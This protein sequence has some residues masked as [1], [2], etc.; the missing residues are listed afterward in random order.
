MWIRNTDFI[1]LL[2]L[3]NCDFITG[4][5]QHVLFTV[6]DV[7]KTERGC[8]RTLWLQ[9][10]KDVSPLPTISYRYLILLLNV[11]VFYAFYIVSVQER[12]N[13]E[14]EYAKQLKGWSSKWLGVIEKGEQTVPLSLPTY[15]IAVLPSFSVLGLVI[16][17]LLV[18]LAFQVIQ[19]VIE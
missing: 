3:Q 18:M 5:L 19:R 6:A 13:I 2:Q 15:K 8:V 11:I 16:L 10:S 9:V 12:A 4:C 14:K 7:S 17:F 1:V